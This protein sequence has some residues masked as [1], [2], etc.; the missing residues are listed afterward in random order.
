MRKHVRYEGVDERGDKIIRVV[1]P[2]LLKAAYFSGE[3]FS[4]QGAWRIVEKNLGNEK[5]YVYFVTKKEFER[6]SGVLTGM[7]EKREKLK[8]F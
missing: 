3:D 6:V 1:H 8:E 4:G 7:G 2:D 5:T